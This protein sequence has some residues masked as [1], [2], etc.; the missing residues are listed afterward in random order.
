MS[1]PRP[2]PAR[3]PASASTRLALASAAWV[4]ALVL[5]GGAGT[6]LLRPRAPATH[7][8]TIDAT[9]Y[10]P[11]RLEVR[12]GDTVVWVNKDLFP[13]TV[14]GAG[15]AF[16]SDVLAQGKSWHYTPEKLGAFDYACVFHPTMKGR[17]EVR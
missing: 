15:G 6:V 12:A 3:A 1:A 10:A 2:R 5:A 11:A 17:L 16:D 8:V 7:T 14:T 9:S 13:H 4:G